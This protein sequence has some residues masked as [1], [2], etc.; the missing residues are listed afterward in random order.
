MVAGMVA[1]SQQPMMMPTVELGTP[2]CAHSS[3]MVGMIRLSACAC[4]MRAFFKRQRHAAVASR[5][6]SLLFMIGTPCMHA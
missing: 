5:Q 6:L 3:V 1:M 2:M 4:S